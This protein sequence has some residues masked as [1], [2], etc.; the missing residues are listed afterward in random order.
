MNSN[1]PNNP[2]LSVR[3]CGLKDGVRCV[4]VHHNEVT[5]RARVWIE[6]PLGTAPAAAFKSHSPYESD[7]KHLNLYF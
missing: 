5:L 3:E 6:I 2:S 4:Y 1:H 7:F